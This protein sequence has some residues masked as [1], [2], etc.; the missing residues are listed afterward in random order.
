[1]RCGGAGLA[2]VCES[3]GASLACSPERASERLCDPSS[4]RHPLPPSPP[5]CRVA[6]VPGVKAYLESPLRLERVNN[7]GLG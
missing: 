3:W 4:A 5:T 7:N 6:A 1:M 2:G